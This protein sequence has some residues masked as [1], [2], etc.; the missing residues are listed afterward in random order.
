MLLDPGSFQQLLVDS[1]HAVR[2]VHSACHRRGEQV[3]AEGVVLT[4]FYEQSDRFVVDVNGSDGV[5]CFGFGYSQL[6]FSSG[7]GLGDGQAFFLDIQVR[8]EKCQKLPTAET[9]SQLQIEHGQMSTPI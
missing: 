6:S 9:G 8:P 4:V 1:S 5:L 3:R 7:H 2:A